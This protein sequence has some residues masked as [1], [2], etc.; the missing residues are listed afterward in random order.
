[1]ANMKILLVDDEKEFVTTLSERL[2]MRDLANETAY[3]GEQALRSVD[4]TEPDVLVLD[5][6]MPGMD[7]IEVLSQVK[8]KFPE[9]RVIMLT[10]HG[11][12]LDEEEA[13]RIGIF[14]YLK[15]PVDIEQLVTCIKGAYQDKIQN[16][17]AAAAFA[18]AGE[19]DMAQRFLH[20]GKNK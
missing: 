1:M 3:N 15:K 12:I 16:S 8:K 11:T 6:K 18:E 9:I 4:K 10:G 13:R 17:M 14:D 5:L 7:G 19:H 20:R 2:E